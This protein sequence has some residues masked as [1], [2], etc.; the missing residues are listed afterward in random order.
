[1]KRVIVNSVHKRYEN[2]T[3][4]PTYDIYIFKKQS[5]NTIQLIAETEAQNVNISLVVFL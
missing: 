1:M 5:F 4:I 2:H 3:I